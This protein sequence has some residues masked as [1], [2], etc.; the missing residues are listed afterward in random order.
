[1]G[2][3]PPKL[4][5]LPVRLANVSGNSGAFPNTC[6]LLSSNFLKHGQRWREYCA[7]QP[8]SQLTAANAGRVLHDNMLFC[9]GHVALLKRSDYWYPP[10]SASNWNSDH[11]P[12][13][14]TR[15]PV[16]LRPV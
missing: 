12:H 2:S 9:D 8:P 15:A 13:P 3:K 6:G 1:M 10:R 5:K 11:Q 4:P 16:N 7:I 14:E